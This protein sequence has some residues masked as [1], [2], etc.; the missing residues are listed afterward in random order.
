[1][2]EEIRHIAARVRDLREIGGYSVE[3]MAREFGLPT[4]TYRGYESGETDIPV[5]FLVEVAG[6]FKVELSAILTGGNPHA[7][8]MAVT[9]KGK[10]S[11]VERRKAYRYE[12]LGDTFVRKEAEP[13]LVTVEPKPDG[14]PLSFNAHP[15]QEFDYLL[16]GT[17]RVVVDGHETVLE[18]GDSVYFDSGRE[19]AMQ[20]LGG[21]PARFLAVII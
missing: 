19:H 15:G 6:R 17:L 8:V 7:R 11:G 14:S 5:S 9:R 16:E 12:S 2:L 3:S 4:E 21:R 18:A 1:M 10:G 13:F 20:A